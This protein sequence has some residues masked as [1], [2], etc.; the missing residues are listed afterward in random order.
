MQKPDLISKFDFISTLE[1]IEHVLFGL[2]KLVYHLQKKDCDL[3]VAV[4]GS[5]N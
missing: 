3:L 5:E 4:E 1:A 2:V